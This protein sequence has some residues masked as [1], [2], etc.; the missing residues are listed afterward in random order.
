M[1]IILQ[2]IKQHTKFWELVSS[3]LIANGYNVTS[4]QCKSEMAELKNAYK[5]V[6]DHNAK[7][8]NNKR[9]WQYFDVITINLFYKKYVY[10][11]YLLRLCFMLYLIVIFII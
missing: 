9:I 2:T 5:N 6:K 11:V 4:I 1:N 3:Q 8:G 7:S 10:F